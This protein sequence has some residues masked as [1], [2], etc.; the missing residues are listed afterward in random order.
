[1]DP[2]VPS[3]EQRLPPAQC[4]EREALADALARL[5]RMLLGH[6]CSTHRLESALHYA[7]AAHGFHAEVFAVPTG[8]WMSLAQADEGF[9]HA[10]PTVRLVRVQQWSIALDRLAALD[11]VFNGIADGRLDVRGAHA[12]MDAI[13]SRAPRH[14]TL[15][16]VLAGGTASASAAA[17]FGARPMGILLA[18]LVGLIS[19]ALG[20]QLGRRGRTRLL[21]D[22]SAGV[23]VGLA[24][25]AAGE[26][27]PTLARKPLVLGGLIVNVP[28]L[29]LT[30][31]LSELAHKNL[32]SG[33]ARLLDATMVF[34]SLLFGV[35]SVWALE[36]AVS[37]ALPP[38]TEGLPPSLWVA[39]LATIIAG[40]AFL[41]LFSVHPRD[42]SA[43]VIG[44][45]IAWGAAIT[46][47]RAGLAGP[48]AA[49]VGA[50]ACGL[51]A[52][53]MARLRDRPAQVFLVP[54]IV[55][56]VPGALG[57]ASIDRALYGDPAGG[58]AGALQTL[59][60]AAALALGLVFAN[61]AVPPRKVL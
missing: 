56:L 49:F 55:L 40:V 12:A 47:E 16:V 3:A 34:L 7:A 17:A 28:G 9:T 29:S 43:A 24:A 42:A 4:A 32:V 44:G 54:A 58:V 51:F 38:M 60:V 18:G 26:L 13:Q 36:R 8:L 39:G 45:L 2:I 52:N 37:G 22:F 19:V 21:V 41:P 5:G 48:A 61:A 30:A 10:A 14:H 23:V 15:W 6:G 46:T 35:G 50:L 25:W 20:V 59:M 31:G 33:T 27:D 1:M 57:F 11:G 53:L